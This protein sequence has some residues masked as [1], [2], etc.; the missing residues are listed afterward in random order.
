[1]PPRTDPPSETTT[2][3]VGTGK[4]KEVAMSCFMFFVILFSSSSTRDIP[5]ECIEYV[6]DP[7]VVQ[8]VGIA[9]YIDGDAIDGNGDSW[10]TVEV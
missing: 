8:F 2:T 1:M 7:G 4:K 9:D 6:N 10:F 3:R 5:Q